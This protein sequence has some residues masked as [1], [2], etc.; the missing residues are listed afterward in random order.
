MDAFMEGEDVIVVVTIVAV[1]AAEIICDFMLDGAYLL[2]FWLLLHMEQWISRK[3]R[4]KRPP[5]ANIRFT[6]C[7]WY[8][9]MC[10]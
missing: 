2:I 10:N 3:K 6:Q 1:D 7:F 5:C 4:K 8:G 9:K